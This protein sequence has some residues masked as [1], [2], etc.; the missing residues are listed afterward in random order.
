[1]QRARLRGDFRPWDCVLREW[2]GGGVGSAASASGRATDGADLGEVAQRPSSLA[3]LELVGAGEERSD[4]YWA[5]LAWLSRPP[6]AFW[7]TAMARDRLLHIVLRGPVQV[8]SRAQAL[9]AWI[10]ITGLRLLA[11]FVVTTVAGAWAGAPYWR[12]ITIAALLATSDVSSIRYM[13]QTTKVDGFTSLTAV[14]DRDEDLHEYVRVARRW[15]S[16]P[17]IVAGTVVLVTAVLAACALL[18]PGELRAVHVG[19]LTL[20]AVVLYDFGEAVTVSVLAIAPFALKEAH[21]PHR[22]SWLNPLDS[23]PVQQ[24]VHAW[25]HAM[26]LLGWSTAIYFVLAL[27]L[28][29]PDSI[30]A[31][32][33][34][35]AGFALVALMVTIGGLVAIRSGVRSIVRLTCDQTLQRLQH[36]IDQY[37]PR[38]EKLT[39]DEWRQ[40]EGLIATYQAAREAPT[41]PS[42]EQ[43]LGRA[44]GALAIPAAGFLLAVLA[45]VYAER[46]LDQLMP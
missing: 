38:L 34:P 13:H 43:T 10:A 14:I 22:L 32:M 9:V 2:H 11:P 30:T 37:E 44:L 4:G 27:V 18:A 25:G 20:L 7:P 40:L 12:W 42:G 3:D 46:L 19:S 39:A 16:V 28:L 41:S 8:L 35:I 1:M 33:A 17:V 21:Y 24:M 23:P 26:V 5:D 45:E 15:S 6:I 36:Q 31:L 29:E